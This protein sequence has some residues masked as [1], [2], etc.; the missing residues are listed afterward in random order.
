MIKVFTASGDLITTIHHDGRGG[1][2]AAAWNLVSRNGQEIA[3]GIYIYSVESD[4]AAFPDF[5]G[6]F[7]VVR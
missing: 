2:G 3:S 5:R 6:K 7:V 1:N 4:D